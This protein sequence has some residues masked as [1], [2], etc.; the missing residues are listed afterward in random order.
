ME[1]FTKNVARFEAIV[2]TVYNVANLISKDKKNIIS[3]SM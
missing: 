1:S 3:K 2:E